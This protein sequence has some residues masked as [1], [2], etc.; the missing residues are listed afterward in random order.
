MNKTMEGI[1]LS[2]REYREHDAILSV[3]CKEEGVQSFVARGLR[4]LS[5]KNA[6]ATQVLTHANFYVDYHERKT[7]HGMRTADIIESYRT[8]RE[9]LEKQAIASVLCECIQKAEL[10]EDAFSFLLTAL[11]FL[12]NTKQPYALLALCFAC[13]NRWCGIEP[14]VDGCVHCHSTKGISGISLAHGGFV[15]TK[16]VHDPTTHIQTKEE[17]SCFRLLCHAELEQFP[18]L[19]EYS[20][21]SYE[22]FL[23]IYRFFQ[24]YS[25]ISIKSVRFLSCL[26]DL[27]GGNGI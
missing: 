19:E 18:I 6:A 27:Q 24:E 22:H 10:E 3:L 4:K 12:K 7:M 8:I 17:L 23:M 14:Y 20:D 16:C 1:V 25:G 13:I 11:N 5:S 26:Q 21:W 2:S 9:D 15:C